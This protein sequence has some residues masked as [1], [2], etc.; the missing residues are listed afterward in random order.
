MRKLLSLILAAL[1][2]LTFCACTG[3]SD[4]ATSSSNDVDIDYTE[5]LEKPYN[6]YTYVYESYITEYSDG[7]TRIEKYRYDENG[8]ILYKENKYSFSDELEITECKYDENS[9][10][11]SSKSYENDIVTNETT[12][13][14]N[15]RGD[16]SFKT[17]VTYNF[18]TGE[19]EYTLYYK[20]DYEYNDDGYITKIIQT[21]P[22]KDKERYVEKVISEIEYDEN[23]HPVSITEEIIHSDKYLETRPTLKKSIKSTTYYNE[24]LEK[25]KV[26]LYN[27]Y[28]TTRISQETKQSE[29]G[30]EITEFYEEDGSIKQIN[31]REFYSNGLEKKTIRYDTDNNILAERSYKYNIY[32]DITEEYENF[33]D[34]ESHLYR[35]D[36]YGNTI[37]S[38]STYRNGLPQETVYEL[39]LDE[40]GNIL[41]SKNNNGAVAKYSGWKAFI[42]PVNEKE[43]PLNPSSKSIIEGLIMHGLI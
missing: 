3:K 39:E 25:I 20:I 15:E 18:K 22:E 38:Q 19:Y 36:D 6:P 16:L 43:S 12:Y 40:N 9:R 33:P 2:A 23:Y 34:S 32:G 14:Y 4:T 35:Y 27:E 11:I 31:V 28:G 41:T 13:E 26:V 1:L 30:K 42:Y 21:H 7:R 8:N 10:R 29:D 24:K 37:Y 17:S 5:L